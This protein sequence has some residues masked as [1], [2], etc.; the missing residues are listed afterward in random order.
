[1]TR[2]VEAK[3]SLMK[4][5]LIQELQDVAYYCLTVDNWTDTSNQSY[6]GITIHYL[7]DSKMI[8]KLLGCFPLYKNHTSAYLMK[9]T[10]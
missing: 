6:I 4:E 7:Q 9:S 2:K 10:N 8:G 5:A 3:Y 1:M